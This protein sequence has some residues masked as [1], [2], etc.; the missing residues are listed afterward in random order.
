MTGTC[1]VHHLPAFHWDLLLLR[2]IC[3]Q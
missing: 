2:N 1:A 3:T